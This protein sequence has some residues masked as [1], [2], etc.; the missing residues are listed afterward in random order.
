MAAA[1]SDGAGPRNLDKLQLN[2]E[3]R[4]G[5]SRAVYAAVRCAYD[6]SPWCATVKQT[7]AAAWGGSAAVRG[8]LGLAAPLTSVFCPYCRRAVCGCGST[9]TRSS[10]SCRCGCGWG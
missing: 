1:A 6:L 10:A 5:I 4:L 7:R 8:L 3:E 2:V 9:S